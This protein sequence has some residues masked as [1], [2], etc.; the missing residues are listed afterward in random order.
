[1]RK[2]LRDYLIPHEGNDYQPHSLQKAAL[3][4]MLGLVLL[5]FT[6]TNLQSLL[7]TSSQWMISTILPG[8]I[9]DLT[10]DERSVDAL[11]ELRR[12]P[13]L[14][15]AA[16]LKAQHMAANEYFS[17]Y[18]PDGVSPWYWFNEVG[19]RFVH[20]GENLAIHFTDSDQVVKAWM[21]SPTHRANILNS[22][23]LEIGIGTASGRFE[24][25]NTIY[26]VQL[27]GAPAAAPAPVPAPAP[28]VATASP[29]PVVL[30]ETEST[31]PIE[32]T[33][34]NNN[35]AE[36]QSATPAGGSSPEMI[37]SAEEVTDEATDE[38]V[39][40]LSSAR[41]P[42]L[43]AAP[44]ADTTAAV[45]E[46][47][48]TEITTVA[49]EDGTV[50]L[51]SGTIATSTALAPAIISPDQAIFTNTRT[52]AILAVATKPQTV[53]QFIYAV[54]CFLV[55]VALTLSII[56]EIRRQNPV[57]IAYGVG[58]VALMACLLYVHITLTAGAIII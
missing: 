54:L 14:D 58:M 51:Y 30:A 42:Q 34:T 41:D 57:Q 50:T 45:A 22:D 48:P 24:G 40:T 38:S 19:Y 39:V 8:V 6:L 26:V 5:S 2:Q 3:L 43:A 56:I 13:V 21:N 18:S 36:E 28:V 37:A 52:P 47:E 29:L 9:V 33:P 20:A 32:L 7:W 4:G 16:T 53:L 12:N 44:E 46:A 31:P 11:G 25:Y 1:M 23:Y 27:F 35:N 15:A 10:N 55:L 49:A 17:H